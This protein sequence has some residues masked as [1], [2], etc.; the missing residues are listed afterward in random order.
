MHLFLEGVIWITW[1]AEGDKGCDR[2]MRMYAYN[3]HG[4][5]PTIPTIRRPT[6]RRR[7]IRKPNV[8]RPTVRRPILYVVLPYVICVLF[9]QWKQGI[10]PA[11]DPSGPSLPLSKQ[12]VISSRCH[13]CHLA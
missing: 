9:A 2:R 11:A 1:G 3:I 10:R 4:H 5:R 8:R 12:K 13:I 7:T 6:I